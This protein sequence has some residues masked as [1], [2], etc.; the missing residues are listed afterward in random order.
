MG[1]MIALLEDEATCTCSGKMPIG[2]NESSARMDQSSDRLRFDERMLLSPGIHD[3]TL[4]EVE[5]HFARFQ[6]TDRRIR[7]FA[8]L[9]RYMKEVRGIGMNVDVI[10][11][12]SF[13]MPKVDEPGDIDIVVVMPAEWKKETELR[14]FQ[15]NLISK[16]MTRAEYGFDVLAHPADSTAAAKAIDYFSQVNVK[17][18][19]QFNWPYDTRKRLVRIIP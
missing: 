12:G 18:C 17:W 5:R 3:A 9:K 16:R 13:I 1:K 14:P 4:E 19:E 6:R 11:D 15:Y 7:L 2:V 8:Q 10:I